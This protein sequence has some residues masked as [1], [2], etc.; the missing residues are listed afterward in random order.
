MNLNSTQHNVNSHYATTTRARPL[1]LSSDN[2]H[3]DIERIIRTKLEIVQALF[4]IAT[5]TVIR[6]RCS[7]GGGR[8]R[9]NSHEKPDDD[10]VKEEE[11]GG[12]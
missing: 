2:F 10:N 6:C 4:Q 1:P 8:N 9:D 11:H 7:N 3:V 12:E 5:L